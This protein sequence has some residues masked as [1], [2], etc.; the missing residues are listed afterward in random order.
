MIDHESHKLRSGFYDPERSKPMT[1]FVVSSVFALLLGGA[2]FYS[3]TST[4]TSMTERDCA[5]GVQKACNSLK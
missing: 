5:A 4:L 2:F 3:L 1:N